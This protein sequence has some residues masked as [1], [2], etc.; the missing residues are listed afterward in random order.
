MV[1]ISWER[2]GKQV[3]L[4]WY[5]YKQGRT[6][7]IE[8]GGEIIGVFQNYKQYLFGII[9]QIILQY[10]ELIGGSRRDTSLEMQ[11]WSNPVVWGAKKYQTSHL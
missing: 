6:Q 7:A 4:V 10:A 8:S 1:W 3:T 11:E 9:Q 5:Q 2:S